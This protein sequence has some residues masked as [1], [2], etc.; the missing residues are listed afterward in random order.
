MSKIQ[1]V[2]DLLG[3]DLVVEHI[4][5]GDHS[6]KVKLAMILSDENNGVISDLDA[7]EI[8]NQS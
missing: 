5:A 1:P 8:N 7:V 4:K 2:I 6:I 3:E